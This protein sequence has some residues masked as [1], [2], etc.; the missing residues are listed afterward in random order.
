KGSEPPENPVN[1]M[2]WLDTSNPDV[3]VLRR[4][5]EGQ[6]INATAEKAEDIGAITREKALYSEL[7]NTFVNLS[8]QHSKLLNEMHD[9]MNTEYLV[10]FDLK[11]E[12]N[13]KLDATV[14]IF[15]NIKSNLES[16]TD[17]TATIGKL[18]DTQTLFLNYRTAMQNLYNVVERAKIAIDERFKL[19]QSQYTDEKFKEALNNVADKLGLTINEDNQLVGEIDVSKQ[20]D[21]S[22]RE[23]TNQ[24]LRDYVTS[25][26]YQSDKQGIIERLESSDSERKQL[27][28]RI[29]DT[30]TKSEYQNDVEQKLSTTKAEVLIE[31]EQTSNRVSKEVFNAKSKTLER[32]TSE[33]INNVSE[34]M[35][36]RY[37][38]NG[39]IQ[40]H[41]IGPQGIKIKGDKLDIQLNKEFNLLVSDV[42]K[43]ADETNIINKINLSREGLDIDVN[44][45]GIRGGDSVNYLE[46]K[47][48]SVLSRGR[49]TRTWANK[50]DSANLTLG[51]REGYL[52]VSNEDTGYNLYMTEK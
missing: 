8:I 42:A 15:N 2:L 37:D 21:E 19:L 24:M 25:S 47:N 48:N 43:K 17:E 4:Y 44:N 30:V 23:M 9:V 11:D 10:D 18:I 6:W 3:A 32:Y 38:D 51:I 36:F 31:A 33:F 26:Q 50:T 35:S 12:L 52:M 45:I 39:N 20:I 27:A 29:S 22:V 1:D 13:T 16:M 46:I 5:W 49:F 34:G 28:D 14:S 40:S 41:S 7:T